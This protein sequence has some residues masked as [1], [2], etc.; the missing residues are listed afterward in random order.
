[1]KSKDKKN[2]IFLLKKLKNLTKN[3]NYLKEGFLVLIYHFQS[4]LGLL[5]E[6]K[7]FSNLLGLDNFGKL[8]VFNSFSLLILT[9]FSNSIASAF[10]RFYIIAKKENKMSQIISSIIQITLVT[11]FLNCIYSLFGI[12]TF[13]LYE[14]KYLLVLLVCIFTTFK[15][16]QEIFRQVYII[17]RKRVKIILVDFTYYFVIFVLTYFYYLTKTNI[18]IKNIIYIQF[19]GLITSLIF[20]FSTLKLSYISIINLL[21]NTFKEIHFKEIKNIIKL[22]IPIS[23][24]GLST[25]IQNS[26]SKLVLNQQLLYEEIG[27]LAILQQVYF[28]PSILLISMLISLFYPILNSNLD[29]N[30]SGHLTSKDKKYIRK[31]LNLTIFLFLFSFALISISYSIFNK[32]ILTFFELNANGE[33]LLLINIILISAF[34]QSAIQLLSAFSFSILKVKFFSR[35]VAPFIIIFGLPLIYFL[36]SSYGIIGAVVAKLII[37]LIIFIINWFNLYKYI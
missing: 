33:N 34:F 12:Y 2:N 15:T 32:N 22:S 27:K 35:K 11:I 18:D 24:L 8:N 10:G 30:T 21:N 26:V 3:K 14:S 1:M 31:T 16:I 17:D 25:W 13:S 7:I 37:I 20:S 23:I 4:A 9:T 19:A 28:G 5:L 29:I 36:T 6:L